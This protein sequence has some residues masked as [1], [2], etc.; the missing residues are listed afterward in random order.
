MNS[1]SLMTSFLDL[2]C[3]AFGGAV[4]MLLIAVSSPPDAK[5]TVRDNTLLVWCRHRSGPAAEIGLEFRRPGGT[6]WIPFVQAPELGPGFASHGLAGT[7]AFFL[8]LAPEEG[9]WEFRPLLADAAESGGPTVV[10]A[11]CT[12]DDDT[13]VE[14]SP[15][16]TELHRT[17]DVGKPLRVRVGPR[18]K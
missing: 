7:S 2:V 15:G 5:P 4:L 1:Q 14:H 13:H 8:L 10:E 18:P 12:G 16:P 9:V 6:E 11:E 3:C 17:G